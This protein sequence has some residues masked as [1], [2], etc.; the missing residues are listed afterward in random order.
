MAQS[1]SLNLPQ[2]VLEQKQGIT[3]HEA[4]GL[5]YRTCFCKV[6]QVIHGTLRAKGSK[7]AKQPISIKCG[8]V[9]V[10]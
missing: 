10:A 4:V 2:L 3:I 8:N 9:L 6:E 1:H 5:A 7:L